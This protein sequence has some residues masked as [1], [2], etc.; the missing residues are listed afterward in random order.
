M[1]VT[2]TT[3]LAHLFLGRPS[4]LLAREVLSATLSGPP[5]F[6]GAASFAL[7]WPSISGGRKCPWLTRSLYSGRLR[8]YFLVGSIS[9]DRNEFFA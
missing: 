4:T 2:D 1:I 7:S 9:C 6:C 8:V 5:R 3:L